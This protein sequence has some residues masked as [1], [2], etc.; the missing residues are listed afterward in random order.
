MRCVA[1]GRG[2]YDRG[3]ARAGLLQ[4]RRTLGPPRVGEP[5]IWCYTLWLLIEL[6]DSLQ[7]EGTFAKIVTMILA[8]VPDEAR[9]CVADPNLLANSV[10]AA[11]M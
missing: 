10:Y 3:C 4:D 8:K 6:L 2:R 11:R 9:A 5:L 7:G 1:V